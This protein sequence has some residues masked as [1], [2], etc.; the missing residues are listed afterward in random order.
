MKA[1]LILIANASQARLF[2]REKHPAVLV[3]LASDQY[4]EG[5]LKASEL[6]DDRLGHGASDNRPGGTSFTPR[7]DPRRKKHLQFAKVLAQEVDEALATGQYGELTLFAS[8]PFLGE[9]KGQLSAHAKK[10]LHAAIDMD[11]TSFSL[12]EVERRVDHALHAPH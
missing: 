9:L 10:T 6:A 4:P 7:V 1:E 5:H 3:P 2:R 8:C 11:L 12:D